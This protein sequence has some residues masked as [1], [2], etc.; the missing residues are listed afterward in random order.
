M[1]TSIVL[2]TYNKLEFTIQCIESIR[3]YT[4]P[5]TYELIVVDNCSTDGTQQWLQSQHDIV[6]I[7]NDSNYGFPKG[8]NQGMEIA[9]G[10]AILLLNNDT[11][12]TEN[13]LNNLLYCL[14]SDEKIG[15]V[16]CVTNNCSYAQTIPVSYESLEGMHSF[17]SEYN[18]SNSSKWEERLKLVGFCI[19]MKR[20]IINEIGMLDERFTPGN[21]ED[22]D[23]SLRIRKAGYRLILCKDTFIHHY[24]SVSFREIQGSHKKI[25][26]KNLK[27]FEEKWGFNPDYSQHI[28]F[29]IVDMIANE[30]TAEIKVLEVGC[31]CG[32][33]L[34]EIKNRFKN[35][36]L[37]GIELS[38]GAASI[39]SLIA[40]V[41]NSNI[42]KG[43]LIYPEEYFDYIIFADV[44]E[45]LYDP[46]SVLKYI[47]KHLKSTGKILISLPNLMHHSVIS[48]LLNGN[49][50]Y[51][52]AGILDRTHVRFFTL[53]EIK[54]MMVQTGYF[55]L[56][57]YT[58]DIPIRPQSLTFDL[59]G[60][61]RPEI[62]EQFNVYQYL[63]SASKHTLDKEC[64]IVPTLR[65]VP[66]Q[67]VDLL[68][69]YETN[70]VLTYIVHAEVGDKTELLNI[71][72]TAHFECSD[73]TR[74]L[75]YYELAIKFNEEHSDVLFNLS[76]FL[77]FIGEKEVASNYM[78]R[79]ESIDPIGYQQ[80]MGM[81]SNFE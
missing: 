58:V 49:F 51:T 15:A 10:D 76:Y 17:A 80:L 47:K 12:V 18:V 52:D 30:P 20:D 32:G 13:W 65:Q 60:I 69:G 67:I 40:N 56:Q 75:P 31:A 23:Y 11:I 7:L 9:T 6:K 1:K 29:N 44:L 37:Y 55:K 74:V 61:V 62:Y 5:E 2:L 79:L 25:L 33:T 3:R 27:K 50:T 26:Q 78:Q 59:S 73:Y 64:A 48:D 34:L 21:Y 24:G 70:D 72:G 66:Q 35:A 36:E 77:S 57:V 22:D 53:E 43:E 54:K 28:R 4:T 39:A 46:W 81:I 63:V 19:L 16:S 8:C 42:E 38:E 45:H 14:Y 41:T 68:K 71:I